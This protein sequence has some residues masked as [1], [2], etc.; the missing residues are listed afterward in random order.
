MYDM[1][2]LQIKYW[3]LLF[4]SGQLSVEAHILNISCV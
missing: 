3:L 1:S 4:E 2:V